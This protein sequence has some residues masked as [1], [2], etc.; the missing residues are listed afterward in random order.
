MRRRTL[1]RSVSGYLTLL[2]GGSTLLLTRDDTVEPEQ[3]ANFKL[4]TDVPNGRTSDGPTIS[5]DR[6][7]T[8]TIVTGTIERGS[9]CETV[10]PTKI[11]YDDSDET[12]DIVI[13]SVQSPRP[14]W[15]TSCQPSLGVEPYRLV[16]GFP[17]SLPATI[18]VTERPTDGFEHRTAT[19]TVR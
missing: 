12:L 5:I 9:S 17:D 14:V 11:S 2:L 18:T 7:A 19:K 1:F 16:V 13:A 15:M 4:L 10:E 3:S 8:E 6:G